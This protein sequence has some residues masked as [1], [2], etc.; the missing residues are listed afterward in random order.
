[1]N[2]LVHLQQGFL[3]NILGLFALAH[4]TQGHPVEHR[5]MLSDELLEGRSLPT[6]EGFHKIH[7]H[8]AL[9]PAKCGCMSKALSCPAPLIVY[10]HWQ[11]VKGFAVARAH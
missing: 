11:R 9:Q 5:S 7:Q 1:V 8:V 4:Q 6:L 2:V 3:Q 10:H